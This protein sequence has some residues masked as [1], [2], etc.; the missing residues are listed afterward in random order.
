[1]MGYASSFKDICLGDRLKGVLKTGDIG[2]I[3]EDGFVTISGRASRIGKVYGLRVN[4]DELESYLSGIVDC[5][6]VEQGGLLL[7]IVHELTLNE[8]SFD[9]TTIIDSL[10][11]AFNIPRAAYHFKTISKIPMTSNGKVDYNELKRSIDVD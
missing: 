7:I 1:M 10:C 5:V 3:D 11:S 8:P 4:L 6:V 2:S 9:E